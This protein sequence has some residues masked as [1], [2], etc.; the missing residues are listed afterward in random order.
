[1]IES[2]MLRGPPAW[3]ISTCKLYLGR[4]Q[5]M[6]KLLPTLQGHFSW[7]LCVAGPQMGVAE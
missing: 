6:A 2:H 1:M 5:L 7:A 4:L 3:V